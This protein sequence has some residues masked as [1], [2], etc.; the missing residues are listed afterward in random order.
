MA[1]LVLPKG[2]VKLV[3]DQLAAA[4]GENR[5]AVLLNTPATTGCCWRRII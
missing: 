3:V 5:E 1:A 2:I 4:A